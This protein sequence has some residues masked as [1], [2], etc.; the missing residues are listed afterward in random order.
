MGRGAISLG[1]LASALLESLS[2][3]PRGPRLAPAGQSPRRGGKRPSGR[4]AALTLGGGCA[5]LSASQAPLW[6]PRRP[7]STPAG[8]GLRPC[9]PAGLYGPRWVPPPP[10]PGLDEMRA[11]RAVPAFGRLTTWSLAAPAVGSGRTGFAGCPQPRLWAGPAV[12]GRGGC[13][14]AGGHTSGPAA[15]AV[16][17]PG[18]GRGGCPRAGARPGLL[19]GRGTGGG[20]PEG[21]TGG[22]APR[23]AFVHATRG[24]PLCVS[25]V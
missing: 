14:G 3:P 22:G 5:P 23:S 21:A 13:R 2:R 9:P 24:E 15:P 18:C 19:A 6:G 20:P 1:K 17:S 4:R 10:F 8:R 11:A 12:H 25:K 16:H 7:D